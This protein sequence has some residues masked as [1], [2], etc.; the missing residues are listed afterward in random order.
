[1]PARAHSLPGHCS[2][3]FCDEMGLPL[4]YPCL[5]DPMDRGAWREGNKKMILIFL[6]ESIL[7]YE[8]II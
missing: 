3:E 7:G 2:K 4:H 6:T 1:M 8:T 5:E